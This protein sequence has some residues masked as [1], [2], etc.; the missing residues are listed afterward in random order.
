MSTTFDNISDFTIV[1]RPS[2]EILRLFQLFKLFCIACIIF[3]QFS[4]LSAA[5]PLFLKITH[6]I[7]IPFVFYKIQPGV[8]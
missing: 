3:S 1:A 7:C 6:K 2:F 8:S 5:V 4:R